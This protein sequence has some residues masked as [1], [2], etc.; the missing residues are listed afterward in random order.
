MLK[1]AQASIAARGGAGRSDPMDSTSFFKANGF[2]K[3]MSNALFSISHGVPD[4]AITG[5]D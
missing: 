3:T 2:A 4:I 5:M 1:R